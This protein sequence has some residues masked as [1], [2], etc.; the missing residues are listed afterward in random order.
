M[1]RRTWTELVLF[2]IGALLIG[3]ALFVNLTRADTSE[4]HFELKIDRAGPAY[5]MR[6]EGQRK[7]YG[8]QFFFD[9]ER[10]TFTG[11]VNGDQVVITG[12]LRS[13]DA[14]KTRDFKV[15]GSIADNRMV[16]NVMSDRGGR[17]GRITLQF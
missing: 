1:R 15:E 10:V 17:I 2:A 16:S 13:G 3:H 11:E 14:K 7:I 6:A 5:E 12:T 4:F 8:K 9:G